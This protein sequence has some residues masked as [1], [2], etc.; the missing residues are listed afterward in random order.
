[1][2][3]SERDTGLGPTRSRERFGGHDQ[4]G[5]AHGA[6]E[7]V[8]K[9][10]HVEVDDGGGVESEEW[11]DEKAA[12]DG[13][14]E[15]LTQFG[16]VAGFQREGQGAEQG[17]HR[18]HHDGAETEAA[19]LIDGLF[20]REPVLAFGVEGEI[21]HHNGV[22]LYDADEED[23]ADEGDEGKLGVKKE[24]GKEGADAS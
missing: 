19:G 14:A 5:L 21:D 7:P 12:D 9:A 22:L 1:M 16:A 13:D 17:G 11:R 18:G 24:Q 6:L 3:G 20:G 10:A 2:N 4:I 8:G 15:G 23:N